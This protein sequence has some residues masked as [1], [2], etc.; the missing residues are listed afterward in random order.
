[1]LKKYFGILCLTFVLALT[2]IAPASAA[3]E[4]QSRKNSTNTKFVFDFDILGKANTLGRAK[5]DDSGTY[6]MAY[7]M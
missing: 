3:S 1:M 2:A 7:T 4:P 5:Q 6:V